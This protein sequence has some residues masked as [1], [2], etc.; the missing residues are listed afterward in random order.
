MH[1]NARGY[2]KTHSILRRDIDAEIDAVYLDQLR[3]QPARVLLVTDT[4]DFPAF[5]YVIEL[6][7]SEYIIKLAAYVSFHVIQPR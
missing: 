1:L 3:E 2:R 6:D 7:A 4:H 5:I